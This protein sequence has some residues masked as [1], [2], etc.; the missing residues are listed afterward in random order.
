[1]KET[2][3]PMGNSAQPK[4]INTK[5]VYQYKTIICFLYSSKQRI[6]CFSWNG[7]RQDDFYCNLRRTEIHYKN[8]KCQVKYLY[9]NRRD[10]FSFPE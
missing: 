5:A 8:I 7:I 4:I 10:I 1:M 9:E 6:L 3:I 2:L